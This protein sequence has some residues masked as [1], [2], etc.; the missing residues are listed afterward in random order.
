MATVLDSQERRRS[1]AAMDV[2]AVEYDGTGRQFE[3]PEIG[4][5]DRLLFAGWHAVCAVSVSS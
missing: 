2:A 4:Q 5:A 1:L 3:H